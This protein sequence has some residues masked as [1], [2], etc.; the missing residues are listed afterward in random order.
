MKQLL[1]NWRGYLKE[2]D[3]GKVKNTPVFDECFEGKGKIL[4]P[5]LNKTLEIIEMV[6]NKNI[7]DWPQKIECMTEEEIKAGKEEE[8]GHWLYVSETERIKIN[9]TMDVFN[10]YLNFIHEFIH[11]AKPELG[12]PKYSTQHRH[13]E[14]NESLMK[15]VIENILAFLNEEAEI[16]D[17]IPPEFIKA[18]EG[19]D[20]KE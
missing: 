4:G 19:Y 9:P 20:E 7:D 8:G 1:E 11:H 13:I 12:G 16:K 14:I 10:I 2:T 3:L 15:Q 6:L 5:L 18:L 17:K